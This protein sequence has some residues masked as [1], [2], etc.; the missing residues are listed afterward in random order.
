MKTLFEV[1]TFLYSIG[2]TFGVL[3]CLSS[4]GMCFLLGINPE[5]EEEN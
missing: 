3:V 2:I 4:L 5:I 1:Q